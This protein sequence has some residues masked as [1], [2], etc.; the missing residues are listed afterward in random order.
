[1][2]SSELLAGED[3]YNSMAP[4]MHLAVVDLPRAVAFDA[5]AA[6]YSRVYLSTLDA[7]LHCVGTPS[8]N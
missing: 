2:T 7:R 4:G 6:A 1:V 8:P 3:T 5:I